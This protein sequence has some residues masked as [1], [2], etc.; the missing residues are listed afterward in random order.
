MSKVK[1]IRGKNEK[2]EWVD[3][4]DKKFKLQ[5]FVEVEIE[6]IMTKKEFKDRY[7]NPQI[8]KKQQ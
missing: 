2:G 1:V 8:F 4:K 3:I 6:E 7:G 5:K